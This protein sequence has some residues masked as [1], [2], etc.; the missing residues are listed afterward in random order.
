[1][2]TNV[3]TTDRAAR[4][5]LGI[6]LLAAPFVTGLAIFDSNTMTTVS[7]LAGL[8]MLGT[9]ALKVCPLYTVFGIRTCK[10]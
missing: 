4:L 3:G 2:K 8:V 7:V 6:L 5:A 10:S 1:M 9:S